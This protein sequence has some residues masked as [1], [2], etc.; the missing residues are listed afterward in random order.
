[1]RENSSLAGVYFVYILLDPTEEKKPFFVGVLTQISEDIRGIE[2]DDRILSDIRKQLSQGVEHFD[3]RQKGL[4]KQY[5][6]ST[7]EAH[8]IDAISQLFLVVARN[9][10]F[11]YAE[12]LRDLI[13]H[14]SYPTKT[15]GSMRASKPECL[16]SYD[17]V[18]GEAHE[19][20]GLDFPADPNGQLRNTYSGKCGGYY[21]YALIDPNKN[22]IF[23]VG[24]GKGKRVWNHFR[25]AQSFSEEE[26]KKKK[27]EKLERLKAL[28]DRGDTPSNIVKILARVPNNEAAY[29][30]ETFCMKFIVGSRDLE[31][32]TSG[33]YADKI[34]AK[35]DLKR[36]YG[37]DRI[38]KREQ[39]GRFPRQVEEDLFKGA[40]LEEYLSEFCEAFVKNLTDKSYGPIPRFS[41]AKI[42]GAGELVRDAEFETTFGKVLL[43][44][45]MRS[46]WTSSI[47]CLIQPGGNDE[48]GRGTPRERA[49]SLTISVYG[50]ENPPGLRRDAVFNCNSWKADNIATD[51]DEAIRRATLLY[52]V[53]TE[54]PLSQDEKDEIFR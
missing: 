20:P 47:H 32:S 41:S 34:R 28:L 2:I 21:V 25:D 22:E 24:K 17:K 30:T 46:P 50:A 37:F 53:V 48:L 54:K 33:K 4:Y 52:K 14:S 19:V 43:R 42:A 44:L 11:E 45:Q 39:N 49:R 38:C 15:F 13:L 18:F 26:M 29:L 40:G 16:R 6:E 9:L 27:G 10:A 31:N 1:M 35:D 8:V 51:V 12:L 23:Y 7:A 5:F 3:D 36:R